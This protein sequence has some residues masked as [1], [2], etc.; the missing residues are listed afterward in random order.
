MGSEAKKKDF[1]SH[2]IRTTSIACTA[3]PQVKIKYINHFI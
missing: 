3:E 2:F 1:A